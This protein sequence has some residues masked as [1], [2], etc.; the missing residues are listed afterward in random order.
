MV[1]PF[2]FQLKIYLQLL[3]FPF[4]RACHATHPIVSLV[5]HPNTHIEL[6][7]RNA[8]DDH[9]GGNHPVYVKPVVNESPNQVI[10]NLPPE[11]APLVV[12]SNV[13]IL[14]AGKTEDLTQLKNKVVN[15]FNTHG[16]LNQ[17]LA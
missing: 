15:W 6:A 8:C 4:I 14:A 7:V 10:L 12:L 5:D 9:I 11:A 13:P 17:Y 2:Y 16:Y 3:R 1:F